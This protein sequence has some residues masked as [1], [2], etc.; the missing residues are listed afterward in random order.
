MIAWQNILACKEGENVVHF[1][2][3]NTHKIGITF[4]SSVECNK[5]K[6]KRKHVYKHNYVER[7]DVIIIIC[8]TT[9]YSESPNNAS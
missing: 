1:L 2:S 3:V 8:H 5:E 6:M 9:S 7:I 4:S